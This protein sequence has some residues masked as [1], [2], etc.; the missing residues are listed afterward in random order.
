MVKMDMI[1]YVF[2]NFFMFFIFL[3]LFYDF[4]YDFL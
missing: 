1:F 3:R 4:V 2:F